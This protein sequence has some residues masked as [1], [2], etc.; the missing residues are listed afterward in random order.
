MGKDVSISIDY[1]TAH[2]FKGKERDVVIIVGANRRSF[3]KFHPDNELMEVL[4]VTMRR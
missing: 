3:P 4:G 2:S 1:S